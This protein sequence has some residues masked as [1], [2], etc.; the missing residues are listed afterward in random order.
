MGQFLVPFFHSP[1]PQPKKINEEWRVEYMTL[2][3]RDQQMKDEGRAE[4][5]KAR[6]AVMLRKGKE[7]EKIA[8]FCDY[9]LE[10]VL[11]VRDNMSNH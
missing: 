5:Q 4:E 1:Y 3:L 6:I 9:P 11:E 2:M 10:T 7:P 8:E